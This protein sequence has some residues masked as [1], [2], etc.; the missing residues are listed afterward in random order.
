MLSAGGLDPD[1][2][3]II[4]PMGREN[5]RIQALFAGSVEATPLP[6]PLH[7]VAE[8]KGYSL[9]ADIEGKFEVPFSGLTVTD[10]KLKENP[11]EVKK[12]IRA[13]VKAGRFF[14]THHAESVALYMDW[15]KLSKPI[16]EGAYARSLRTVSPDGLGKES[17]IK[18]QFELIKKT[19]GK[20]VKQ[21]DVIDSLS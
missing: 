16:A 20:D 13:L 10:R 1:K 5:V 11:E 17:A 15:L 18:T 2:D 7:A 9:V 4:I 21:E 12:M 8:E 3:V 19:T 14:L 6:V